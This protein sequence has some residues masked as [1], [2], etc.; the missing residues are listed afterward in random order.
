MAFNSKSQNMWNDIRLAG[1]TML[2]L[3]STKW[4][5][6]HRQIKIFSMFFFSQKIP[7]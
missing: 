5:E 6:I 7:H 4:L 2:S 3:N 1:F